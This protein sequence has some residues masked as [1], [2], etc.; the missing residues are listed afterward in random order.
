MK[1]LPDVISYSQSF[2][3]SP[4]INLCLY[5]VQISHTNLST[6]KAPYISN[7]DSITLNPP[8]L[9]EEN[10]QESSMGFSKD[11]T[12]F[13][14]GVRRNI[15][16]SQNKPHQRQIKLQSTIHSHGTHNGNFMPY[17]GL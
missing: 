11:V 13:D 17:Q 14:L 10:S 2:I 4:K 8:Y 6:F 9:A 16:F 15:A 5:C 12:F 1:F 3:Y 7:S